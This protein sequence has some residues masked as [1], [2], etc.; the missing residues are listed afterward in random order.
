MNFFAVYVDL[1]AFLYIHTFTYI[2]VLKLSQIHMSLLI[3]RYR[4][5]L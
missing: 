4:N 5:F 1:E 3:G 2:R